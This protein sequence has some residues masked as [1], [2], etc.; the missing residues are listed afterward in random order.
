MTETSP[1]L[2]VSTPTSPSQV[3]AAEPKPA[4]STITRDHVPIIKKRIV[5]CCDG[6]WQ[7]GLEVQSSKFTNVLRLARSVNYQGCEKDQSIVQVVFYQSGVGTDDSLYS[8]YVDGATGASLSEKVQEAY[9]FIAHNYQPGDE[10]TVFLIDGRPDPINPKPINYQ[11]AYTARMVAMLIGEIGVLD[12]K[13]MN[14]FADIFITYLELGKCDTDAEKNR[15]KSQL[16]KWS[17]QISKGRERA[18][19][20][21]DDFTI[22]CIGVFDT[23]CALGLPGGLSVNPATRSL[24]GFSDN[25]L[26][27]H[28]ERA[29]HALALNE[30]RADFNVAKFEQTEEGKKRGQK[31]IQCWFTGAH[32]DIGG[33]YEHHDLADL[34]LGWMTAQV[35]DILSLDTAYLSSLGEPVAPWGKQLPHDSRSGIFCIA[36]AIQRQLPS[37]GTLSSEWIHSSVLE[38]A[39][40]NPLLKE[41][42]EKTPALV[43]DLMPLETEL[44]AG[45][46]YK[47]DSDNVRSYRK[48]STTESALNNS[49]SQ[50]RLSFGARLGNTIR[51]IIGKKG[52]SKNE[53]N[54]LSETFSTSISSPVSQ[55]S[56]PVTR[57]VKGLA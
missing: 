55:P 17:D 29:Y 33:G 23:V 24:F 45:W 5:V 7:D 25:L 15:L 12:R 10:G 28:I 22:K 43:C 32:S 30:T 4:I 16:S 48:R 31:L 27:K 20:D 35:S 2:P 6:T 50:N 11:G 19:P 8:H 14:H 40:L 42:L 46:L 18:D 13:D 52:A 44:K 39:E 34:T 41:L 49:N 36:R 51:L 56:S 54:W 47:E 21:G 57:R 37:L 38:Q 26:G 53:R 9:G 1:N 3:P